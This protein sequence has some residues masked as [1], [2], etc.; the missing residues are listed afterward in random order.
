MGKFPQV[1]VV[2]PMT[3]IPVHL[4]FDFSVD[5]YKI[6]ERSQD[7]ANLYVSFYSSSIFFIVEIDQFT[8]SGQ[9][10]IDSNNQLV[11]ISDLFDR[12]VKPSLT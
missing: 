9:S 10:E 4:F 6:V 3:L 12:K 11:A 8:I 1:F 7:A 2:N 5:K